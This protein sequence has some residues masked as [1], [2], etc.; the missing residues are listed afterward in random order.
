MKSNSADLDET[1]KK[2]PTHLEKIEGFLNSKYIF[3]YNEVMGKIEG[4]FKNQ[5]Q[6][7]NVTDY[8]LN[9]LSREMIKAGIPEWLKAIKI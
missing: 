3:R 1:I 7:M 4:S 5:K 8:H 9:S 2:K 6:F